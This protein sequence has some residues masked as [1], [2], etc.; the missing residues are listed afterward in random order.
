MKLSA[1][2]F[3]FGLLC[4]VG[5]SATSS[6][7]AWDDQSATVASPHSL[8]GISDFSSRR[9][10][11]RRYVYDPRYSTRSYQPYYYGRPIEYRPYGLVPFFFGLSFPYRT[12]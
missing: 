1:A 12:W 9:R 11:H 8:S 6:A 10:S 4:C 7:A 3:I 5:V 2:V